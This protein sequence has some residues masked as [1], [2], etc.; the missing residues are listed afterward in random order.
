[1]TGVEQ[2]LQV[3]QRLRDPDNGC[4]W[5]VK[6]TF[7][8][9]LPYTIEETYE[10]VDAIQSG[11]M[12]QIK[13]EL[14]DLLFQVVFYAQLGSEQQQFDFD[15]IAEQTATKLIRRHPH[16]FG[17]EEQRALSDAEIKQQWEQIKRQ[18]REQKPQNASVFDDI[19]S[20]LPSVLKAAKLQKRASSVGFDWPAAE[21]VYAKIEEEIEEVKTA[22]SAE[23]QEEEVGDLLFAVIN[24]ARHLQVNP[25]RALQRANSKFAARFQAIEAQLAQQQKQ[26]KD[27]SLDELEGY[28][29]AV[30]KQVNSA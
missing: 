17:S 19:P 20:Q 27:C 1:M 30:K 11:D 9:L 16:V 7:E 8:S 23:H 26:P 12:A 14:G 13:D 10:V 29:Q 4:P 5:D 15:G 28:W 25:E 22:T 2:L 6:Q 21:P 24:L 3:M 18:E